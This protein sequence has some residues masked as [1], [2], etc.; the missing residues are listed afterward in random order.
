MKC[1][2]LSPSTFLQYLHTNLHL[3]ALNCFGQLVMNIIAPN[4]KLR[5]ICTS[6][7]P[8]H[9]CHH[10]QRMSQGMKKWL[11]TKIV[12]EIS[13]SPTLL[14]PQPGR[15]VNKKELCT[16]E[17]KVSGGKKIFKILVKEKPIWMLCAT[18]ILYSNSMKL[19]FVAKS[20]SL[21]KII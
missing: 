3:P 8:N 16:Q 4:S 7:S 13:S 10:S 21:K 12:R 20:K 5:T 19:D 14:Y 17:F 2:F 1:L 6:N 18:L 9:H 15:K 11:N